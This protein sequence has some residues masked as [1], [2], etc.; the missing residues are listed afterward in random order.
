[1]RALAT[2]DTGAWDDVADTDLTCT[3]PDYRRTRDLLRTDAAS[4]ERH[5]CAWVARCPLYTRLAGISADPDVVSVKHALVA[6]WAK[7]AQDG[8]RSPG[9]VPEPGAGTLVFDEAQ[10]LE[11]PLTTAWTESVGQSVAAYLRKYGGANRTA[12]LCLSA[13]KPP[14]QRPSSDARRVRLLDPSAA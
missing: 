1:V 6:A 5:D 3:R 11:D 8:R 13:V 12:V 7:L 14:P 10:D 4:C 2:G 9:G